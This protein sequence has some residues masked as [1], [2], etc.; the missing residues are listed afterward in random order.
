MRHLIVLSIFFLSAS[1]LLYVATRVVP[2]QPMPCPVTQSQYDSIQSENFVNQTII[3]R[4]QI[5][6][7][8]LKEEDSIAAQKFEYILSTKTE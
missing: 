3:M 5:A 8:M 2:R 4:Y 7:D 6:L 1:L